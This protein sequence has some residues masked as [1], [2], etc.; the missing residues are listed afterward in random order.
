MAECS[1][2]SMY[3]WQAVSCFILGV[4]STASRRCYPPLGGY[5][6]KQEFLIQLAI[7]Q[8]NGQ[9]IIHWDPSNIKAA[10]ADAVRRAAVA[11]NA[12]AHDFSPSFRVPYARGDL[13]ET[14]QV[15]IT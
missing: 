14:L 15:Q 9:D 10:H 5:R 1:L 11:K 8:R 2:S 13:T 12:I 7:A 4:L 3:K 6:L